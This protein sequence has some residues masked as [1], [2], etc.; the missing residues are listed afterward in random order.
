MTERPEFTT[1]EY[2]DRVR[3]IASMIV[4][5]GKAKMREH[6]HILRQ[7]AHFN[8]FYKLDFFEPYRNHSPSF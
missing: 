5:Q 8:R 6:V 2:R 1:R 3:R 7:A 4:S